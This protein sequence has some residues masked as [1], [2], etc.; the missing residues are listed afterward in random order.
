MSEN[1]QRLNNLGSRADAAVE[2]EL[3]D[4]LRRGFRGGELYSNSTG[5]VIAPDALIDVLTSLRGRPAYRVAWLGDVESPLVSDVL[6]WVLNDDDGIYVVPDSIEYEGPDTLRGL[7]FIQLIAR[8][9]V[10]PARDAAMMVQAVS[11]LSLQGTPDLYL[12]IPDTMAL[13]P[14]RGNVESIAASPR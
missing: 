1:W 9:Q 14:S 4:C 13:H 10:D 5:D 12:V 7:P 3:A 2:Q 8:S 6:D 11:A